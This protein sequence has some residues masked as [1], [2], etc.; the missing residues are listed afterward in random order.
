M[1]GGGEG[2]GREGGALVGRDRKERVEEVGS[3]RRRGG[4]SEAE[5]PEDRK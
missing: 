5:R 3:W 4:E 2:K 1:V